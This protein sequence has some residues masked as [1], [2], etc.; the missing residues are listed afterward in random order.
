MANIAR[1]HASDMARAGIEPVIFVPAEVETGR[2]GLTVG[3]VAADEVDNDELRVDVDT[4]VPA[5]DVVV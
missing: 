4:V 3:R 5:A 1:M 2:L